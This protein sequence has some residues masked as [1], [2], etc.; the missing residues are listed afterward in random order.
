[1][2]QLR[3]RYAGLSMICMLGLVGCKQ[4]VKIRTEQSGGGVSIA[5]TR[6]QG[7]KPA[8]VSDISVYLGE[9]D[10]KTPL[11]HIAAAPEAACM[12]RFT[13]GTVPAGFAS[14]EGSPAPIWQ[15]GRTYRVEAS[16]NGFLGATD[17]IAQRRS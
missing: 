9:P 7:S 5:V 1:M 16:G 12:T 14:D 6:L 11:W 8:C 4:G 13:L 2:A 10:G 15:P 3:A 17:F